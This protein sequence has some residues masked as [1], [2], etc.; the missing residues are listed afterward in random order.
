MAQKKE[1]RQLYE[2]KFFV[3]LV[4]P[5]IVGPAKYQLFK[6]NGKSDMFKIVVFSF[7]NR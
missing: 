7:L 2:V 4:L 3:H 1:D 5:Y 6:E